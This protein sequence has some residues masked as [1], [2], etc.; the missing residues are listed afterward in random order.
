[1]NEAKKEMNEMVRLA[2]GRRNRQKALARAEVIADL[3]EHFEAIAGR[4]DG[5]CDE[6]EAEALAALDCLDALLDL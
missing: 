3:V 1:M 2:A 5:K 4:W 6:G